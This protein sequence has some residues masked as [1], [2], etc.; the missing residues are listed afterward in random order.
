MQI[1][2]DSLKK[3]QVYTKNEVY[4]GKII[5]LDI[6]LI[7]HRVKNYHVSKGTGLVKAFVPPLLVNPEKI[8][9]ITSEKI[10]VD[11]ALAKQ[12]VE[13]ESASIDMQKESGLEQ[14]IVTSNKES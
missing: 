10:I 12:N 11:D 8:I 4:L 7:N 13:E 3:L 9:E 5:S 14:G 1:E 2:F 6:D